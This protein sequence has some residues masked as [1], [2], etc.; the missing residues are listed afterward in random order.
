MYHISLSCFIQIQQEWSL[1][2]VNSHLKS[3]NYYNDTYQ[4]V[5][6]S[7]W[8]HHH[9]PLYAFLLIF[10][11]ALLSV[12]TSVVFLLPTE[13][14]NKINVGKVKR[15]IDIFQTSSE[16]VGDR[17]REGWKPIFND[18]ETV[19]LLNKKLPNFSL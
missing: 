7:Y 1:Y 11:A 19:R 14:E 18:L 8:I 3:R 5:V 2:S 17:I 15:F 4:G 12:M 6:I 9:A 13:D 10:P 16:R